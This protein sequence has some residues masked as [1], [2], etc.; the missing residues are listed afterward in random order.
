M[1]DQHEAKASRFMNIGFLSRSLVKNNVI[2]S[3]LYLS[4][5]VLEQLIL[6]FFIVRLIQ[7]DNEFGDIEQLF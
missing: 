4:L 5:I 2:E 7:T 6:F 3:S 1:S